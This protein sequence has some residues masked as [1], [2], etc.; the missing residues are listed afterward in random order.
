ML[1]SNEIRPNERNVINLS[2]HANNARVID[3][4]NEHRQQV[5]QQIRLFLQVETE[6]LVIAIEP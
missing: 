3:T 4:R 2:E 5:G 1:D 6:R